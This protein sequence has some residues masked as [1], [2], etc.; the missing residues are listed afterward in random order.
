[1]KLKSKILNTI[2]Y[3]VEVNETEEGVIID[4]FYR[5]GDLIQTYTFWNEDTIDKKGGE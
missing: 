3:A 4:V 5:H 2:H 1:M